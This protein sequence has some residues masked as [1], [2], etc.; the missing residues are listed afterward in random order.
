MHNGCICCTLRGD[1]LK[2]VKQLALD[3]ANYD[4]LVIESTGISEPLPVAQTFV[5]N[6]N[7]E[8]DED[9]DE[10]G[11]DKGT[12]N[13]EEQFEP[14]SNYARMDTLVTVID[15]FNFTSILGTIE[16]ES[17]R[18]K[19]F[20]SDDVEGTEGGEESIVQLLIDQIEFCN[21]ILL[22]KI[23]LLTD[24][25]SIDPIKAVIQ[26][27]NPKATIIIPDKPYFNDFNVMD[28]IINTNLFNME[29]AQE[30][31]G[32]I[33]ELE[34]S[35]HTPET[36]EY[37]VN[38][39]VFRNDERPFH[40]E[41]LSLILKNF[42]TGLVKKIKG[43]SSNKNDDDDDKEIFSNVIRCKGE[44]WLSN[45]DA[46]PI[47]VHSVGRQ[48]VLEPA[49]RPWM[50]KVVETHPNGDPEGANANP[51]DCEV[52]DTFELTSQ[53]IAD[54]KVEKKWNTRFGDRRTELVFIG[55]KLNEKVMRGELNN[56]L[57]TDKELN[58]SESEKKKVWADSL[59][60]SFFGGMSLW[61]LE[62]IMGVE[63]DGEDENGMCNI[64]EE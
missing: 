50:G 45:V 3:D 62:D 11:E 28:T 59:K 54:M 4:Y 44:L 42:G 17:D 8:E 37:G 56:A 7:E 2:T 12:N 53:T 23:D 15:A 46:C 25:S 63:E 22:N 29:E 39:F 60:D 19:Y 27:L 5:L 51:E 14:L 32:W 24:K 1:L 10:G 61:D 13:E 40:P 47:D 38:S 34:K 52:W 41:R 6:A 57:L 58:V 31:A 9:G 21:V 20:G 55:I 36:E 18:T 35:H 48:L 30:G 43:E 26:K 33:A 64:Q 49:G 16:Q